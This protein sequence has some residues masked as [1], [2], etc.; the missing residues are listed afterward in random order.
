MPQLSTVMTPAE[1]ASDTGPAPTSDV[2]AVE[3]SLVSGFFDTNLR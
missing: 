1:I 3:Q 2:I